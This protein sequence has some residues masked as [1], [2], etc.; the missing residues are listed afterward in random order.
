MCAI[1]ILSFF[2][3]TLFTESLFFLKSIHYKIFLYS[4]MHIMIYNKIVIFKNYITTCLWKTM[5]GTVITYCEASKKI[6]KCYWQHSNTK[7]R[8]KGRQRQLSSIPVNFL[9]KPWG[10]L[11]PP[12]A[13]EWWQGKGGTLKVGRMWSLW[14]HDHPLGI[15]NAITF[16]AGRTKR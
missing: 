6:P 16:Q 14:E 11:W 2:F 10:C 4:F 9:W 15:L 12:S 7:K 5:K 1:W 8:D 13:L 3:K